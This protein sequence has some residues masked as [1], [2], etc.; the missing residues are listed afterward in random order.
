MTVTNGTD[1]A[2]TINVRLLSRVCKL[3][4]FLCQL[5]NKPRG[6]DETYPWILLVLYSKEKCEHASSFKTKTFPCLCTANKIYAKES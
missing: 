3:I 4:L 1:H 6:A 2:K 5:K